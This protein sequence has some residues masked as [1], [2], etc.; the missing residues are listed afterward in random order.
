VKDH[1]TTAAQQQAALRIL[2]CEASF[3]EKE[4]LILVGA[5]QPGADPVLD[6]A[7]RLRDPIRGFL[8]QTPAEFTPFGATQRQLGELAARIEAATVRRVA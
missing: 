7:I 2:Q 8:Q 4:D 3:R 5:Y 1:V 6:A